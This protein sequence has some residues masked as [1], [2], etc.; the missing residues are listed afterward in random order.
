MAGFIVKGPHCETKEAANR[1]D[2][3][4]HLIWLCED[5]MEITAINRT[6]GYYTL[7]KDGVLI[8]M[9]SPA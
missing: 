9:M 3:M 1:D 7:T 6:H 4:E 8:A 2:A 5:D